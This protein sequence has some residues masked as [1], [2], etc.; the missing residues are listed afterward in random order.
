MQ[1]GFLTH[2]IVAGAWPIT[3]EVA[4]IQQVIRHDSY[5]LRRL[6]PSAIPYQKEGDS[7]KKGRENIAAS[8]NELKVLLAEP[9]GSSKPTFFQLYKEKVKPALKPQPGP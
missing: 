9:T 8:H 6:T 1:I 4:V 2:C 7:Q 3:C 5:A